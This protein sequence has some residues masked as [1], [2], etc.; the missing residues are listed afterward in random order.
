MLLC[1]A[2]SMLCVLRGSPDFVGRAPQDDESE[3]GIAPHNTV[4]LIGVRDCPSFIQVDRPQAGAQLAMT[5]GS[6]ADGRSAPARR[7]M[8]PL[9]AKPVGPPGR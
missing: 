5:G 9:P 7:P 2:A 8:R 3:K 6:A 4:I 1:R